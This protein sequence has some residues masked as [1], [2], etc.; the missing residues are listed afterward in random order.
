MFSWLVVSEGC[1]SWREGECG[2]PE[3]FPLIYG[4][5]NGKEKESKRKPGQDT[6]P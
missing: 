1:Q 2:E 4:S 5:Q 6:V 3:Q